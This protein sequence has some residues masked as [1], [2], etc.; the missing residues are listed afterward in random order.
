MINAPS[1][2]G[3]LRILPLALDLTS[4]LK[5]GSTMPFAETFTIKSPFKTLTFLYSIL[6]RDSESST[7]PVRVYTEINKRMDKTNTTKV[8][9]M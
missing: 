9:F 3:K 1:S 6:D 4:T 7:L 2:N 5:F 8:F